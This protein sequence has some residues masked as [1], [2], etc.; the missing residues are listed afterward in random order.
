SQVSPFGPGPNVG[1]QVSPFGPG[2]NVGPNVGG[3]FKK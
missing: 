2:P 1:P 3:M